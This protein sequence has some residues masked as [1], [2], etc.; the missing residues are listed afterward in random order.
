MDFI[1][2]SD[3]IDG[4]QIANLRAFGDD[5][6]RFSEIFRREWFPQVEW[7]CVQSNRSES[8][9]GVLRGLHYHFHQID[10]W[11]VI[12]GTIR[13]GMVDLRPASPTYKATQLIEMRG[14]DLLGLFIPEG[15]AHGFYAVTDCL[16]LY[17]VNN[18]YNGNDEFGVAWDDPEIGL[19]WGT[20]LPIVSGRDQNNP[21]LSDIPQ[22]AVPRL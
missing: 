7:D 5:R 10:Y 13:A 3:Q 22:E 18:Y 21:C 16:L 1:Q 20:E 4:V 9:A 19:D 17:Y 12:Q 8:K 2:P 14:E 11:H 15:V 6:G